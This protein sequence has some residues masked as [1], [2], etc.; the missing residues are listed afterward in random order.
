M[1]KKKAEAVAKTKAVAKG[2]KKV[3]K[4]KVATK[5]KAAKKSAPKRA[6]EI[7]NLDSMPIQESNTEIPDGAFPAFLTSIA[8]DFNEKITNPHGGLNFIIG[9]NGISFTGIGGITQDE[10]LTIAYEVTKFTK[11]PIH[12][13]IKALIYMAG[14]DSGNPIG[15]WA[16]N[17]ITQSGEVH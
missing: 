13:L 10:A 8:K 6:V 1:A 11:I 17:T 3:A 12:I 4:K 14:Q 9:D 16:T 15:G 5:S 2:G 7:V